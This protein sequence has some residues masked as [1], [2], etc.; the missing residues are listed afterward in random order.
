MLFAVTALANAN[1]ILK[2]QQFQV[3]QERLSTISES[4]TVTS[5]A[6]RPRIWATAI[7][8]AEAH[9]FFGIGVNQFK[10]EA[11]THDLFERGRTLENAHSIPLSLAAETGLIGLAAFLAF[12]GQLIARAGAALRTT[13]PANFAIAL[14]LAAGLIAFG[15]QGL[16]VAQIRVNVITATFFAVAGLLS[17]MA[18]RA[19]DDRSADASAG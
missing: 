8:V 17:A 6:N 12:F 3:V 9:P 1:P 5:T 14:G 4:R 11:A 16:T 7:T 15:L 13:D 19:A 18:L 2:S 10:H